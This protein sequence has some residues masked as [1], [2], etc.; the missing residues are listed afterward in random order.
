MNKKMVAPPSLSRGGSGWGWAT[1]AILL[2][3]ISSAPSYGEDVSNLY[4]DGQYQAVINLLKDAP[5]NDETSVLYLGLSYLK[6]KDLDQTISVWK[7]YVKNAP[8]TE[9]T[10]N[11]S[12][13][14]DPLLKESAKTG[15]QKAIQDEKNLSASNLDP[16]VVA[17]YPFENKGSSEYDALSTGLTEMVITD[18]SQVKTLKV[19]E[20]IRIQALL[21]ELKLAQSGIVDQNVAPKTGRLLGAGKIASGS[22][23]S[24][25]K[26]KL[27]INL[28]MLKTQEGEILSSKEAEGT[29]QEFYKLEKS[30]VV[31]VLC[32][33]G[34][35]PESL[36]E[37]TQAAIGKVHTT[38]FQ[39]FLQFSKG[40]VLRD[41][42]KY[43]EARQAFLKALAADPNFHIAQE[44]LVETPLFPIT[45]AVIFSEENN[46]SNNEN[47]IEEMPLEKTQPSADTNTSEPK[48]DKKD[49]EKQKPSN[50]PE[51]NTAGFNQEGMNTV[52]LSPVEPPPAT[53]LVPITIKLQF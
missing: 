19:L 21:S 46:L 36:D 20:R 2:L 24:K 17:V 7:S 52:T 50:A 40:L 22:F 11:I 43:R 37:A 5:S 41:Q 38:S 39:A 14:L 29:L 3:L 48:G 34:R 1:W 12:Q 42:G 44:K 49:E 18:L 23:L 32:G 25:D 31:Q 26:K 10:R 30:L 28:S 9:A 35:C 16:N 53:V 33:M 45:Q 51:G 13:Y 8:G 47:P 6:L 15:A 4:K 27:G